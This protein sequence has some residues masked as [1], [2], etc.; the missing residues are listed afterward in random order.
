MHKPLL[1]M[2]LPGLK[3]VSEANAHETHWKRAKRA[4]E[5]HAAVEKALEWEMPPDTPL[6]V[7]ITRFG[8]KLL[9][10]DNL[11]GSAKFVRD[12][13]AEFLGIDDRTPDVSWIVGQQKGPY[14]VEVT[15]YRRIFTIEITPTGWVIRTPSLNVPGLSVRVN[16]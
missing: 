12:A 6:V 13:L 16:P 14:A 9:D 4:K 15:I 7:V 8:K 10:D 3:L 11:Q 2:K 1:H 5:Q